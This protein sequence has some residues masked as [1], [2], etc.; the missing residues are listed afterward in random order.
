MVRISNLN[1]NVMEKIL[2]GNMKSAIALKHALGKTSPPNWMHGVAKKFVA[3]KVSQKMRRRRNITNL[4]TL[5]KRGSRQNNENAYR[6]MMARV[7]VTGNTINHSLY[8]YYR[9]SH[10]KRPLTNRNVGIIFSKASDA[11]LKAFIKSRRPETTTLGR[12]LFM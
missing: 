5:Y 8:D 2:N 1:R 10:P 3:N 9:S 6:R 12:K 11:A 7:R 4:V